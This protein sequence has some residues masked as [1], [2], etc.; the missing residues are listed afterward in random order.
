VARYP[1]VF[2][3]F[4]EGIDRTCLVFPWSQRRLLA[5]IAALF[6]SQ[7]GCNKKQG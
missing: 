2:F 6:L 3:A 7:G 1:G 5:F 4:P